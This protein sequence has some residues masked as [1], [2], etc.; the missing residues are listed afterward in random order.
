MSLWSVQHFIETSKSFNEIYN[1]AN[2]NVGK[3]FENGIEALAWIGTMYFAIDTC[4]GLK[5]VHD[6]ALM[7][8]REVWASMKLDDDL[9]VEGF[10]VPTEEGGDEPGVDGGDYGDYGDYGEYGF[11]ED[12]FFLATTK[13]QQFDDFVEDYYDEETPDT[14]GEEEPAP[15]EDEL[16]EEWTGEM[17]YG[18]Q[19]FIFDMVLHGLDLGWSGWKTVHSYLNGYWYWNMG[20]YAGRFIGDIVA[21][22]LW[23]AK[24]AKKIDYWNDAINT[25][26]AFYII[27]EAAKAD[28]DIF[29]EEEADP[30]DDEFSSFDSY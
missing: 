27:A 7:A 28:E 22:S 24:K 1:D 29:G 5:P 26:A 4:K 17:S 20:E 13:L 8:K 6:V 30:A 3:G 23:G 19:V 2:F 16:V 9:E 21:M 15:V 12:D 10:S 11:E 14:Y 25:V 18:E